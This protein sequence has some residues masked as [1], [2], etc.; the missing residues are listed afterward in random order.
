MMAVSAASRVLVSLRRWVELGRSRVLLGWV[1]PF[2]RGVG[3]ADEAADEGQGGVADLAPAA[4]DDERV[5][6][7]GDQDGLGDAGVAALLLVDGVGDAG[8]AVLSFS[9]EMISIGPRSGFVLSALA[10][11]KG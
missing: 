6:A 9:P 8:G 4:V 11:V 1:R 7:V 5:P 3:L 2:G 10:S